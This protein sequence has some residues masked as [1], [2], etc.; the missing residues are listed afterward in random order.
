MAFVVLGSS[1]RLRCDAKLEPPARLS[2]RGAR[3]VSRA[4]APSASRMSASAVRSGWSN[5][6]TTGMSKR[7]GGTEEYEP[8]AHAKHKERAAKALSSPPAAAAAAAAPAASANGVVDSIAAEDIGAFPDSDPAEAL[9]RMSG[10]AG[11]GRRIRGKRG[12]DRACGRR[13][14]EIAVELEPWSP[15]R[16][17]LHALDA[18]G[19]ADFARV[20]AAQERRNGAMPVFYLDVAE[21]LFRKQREAEAVEMLLSALELPARDTETIALVADRLMRYGQL[22]RAIWLYEEVCRLDP[23]PSAAGAQAGAGARTARA[24]AAGARRRAAIS[25]GRWRC[26]KRCHHGAQRRRLRRHRAGVHSWTPTAIIPRLRALGSRKFALD[27]RLIDDARRR[28]ARGHRVEHRRQR[29]GPVGR[30]A[31]RRALYLQQPRDGYR[32]QA[33]ERHDFRVMVPRNTC[34]GARSTANTRSA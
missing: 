11:H 17:Y 8:D 26:S 22:E 34:C 9:Q 5:W 19:R 4:G 23:G 33:L 21:W 3:G 25:S 24:D 27:P 14:P 30:S 15:D 7:S 32:R 31:R 18:A 29:H 13:G 12:R 10:V 2:E 6:S 16:P 20:F 28:S 1:R